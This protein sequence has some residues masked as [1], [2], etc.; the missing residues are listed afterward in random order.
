VSDVYQALAQ[1]RPYRQQ[2]PPAEILEMLRTFA[3]QNHLDS[4]VVELVGRDLEA[5]WRAATGREWSGAAP[6][7]SA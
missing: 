6:R 5:N 3:R 2:L 4:E 7:H 1:Q